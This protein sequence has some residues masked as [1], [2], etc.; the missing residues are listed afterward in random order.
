MSLRVPYGNIPLLFCLL[1]TGMDPARAGQRAPADSV[2]VAYYSD[3]RAHVNDRDAPARCDTL[4]RRAGEAGDLRLQ[5]VALCLRLDHYYFRN[6][7]ERI[8]EHVRRVKEFCAAHPDREELRYFYYFAWGSRLITFHIKQNQSNVAVYETRRMLTEAQEEGYARGVAMCYGLLG[9]LYMTQGDSRS[10]YDNFRMQ[11][12]EITRHGIDEINLPTQYAS[13]AQCALDLNM[14]DSALLALRKADSLRLRSA[15]QRFTVDKSYTLYHLHTGDLRAARQRLDSIEH[16]FRTEPRLATY[17]SG[18]YYIE[19]AYYR[20][21][22]EY[23]KAL[24]VVRRSQRDTVLRKT[25]YAFYVLSR[26]MGDIFYL[27]GDMPRAAASYREYIQAADSVRS[28]EVRIA[29]EDFSG[30]LELGRLQ[31]ETRQM[32]LDLQRRR[33]H[34]TYLVILLLGCLLVAGGALFARIVRLNRRLKV[35]EATVSRQNEHLLSAG[36]EL[37]AAKERAEQVSALKTSFIQNMSHEVRT[38]LNS[39]VGFSQVLASQFRNDTDASEYASIIE[40]SS[41]NLMRLIDDVLDISF[42]DQTDNLPANDCREM[43]SCCRE[44]TDGILREVADGVTV[45]CELSSENPVVR[46]DIRRV[47]QVLNHLLQNAAK[48]TERGTISLSYCCL[49][50]EGVLRFAVT[51]TGPGIPAAMREQ[52][53]ERFVKL[54]AFSQGSG[55]GLPV[56]RVIADKLGGRLY[57]DPTYDA[58]CRMIF[59]IPFLPA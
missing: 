59:E 26:D 32:Q 57:V 45:Q 42:L 2:L 23:G 31:D 9:N 16:A 19:A 46:T 21:A 10:A 36:R 14:P 43:N 6:D 53:F 25:D 47:A 33:L 28:R 17:R 1:L 12:D 22:G 8:I 35:S 3:I 55:L 24:D 18:L 5:A 51:D 54:D 50:E 48:F 13:M 11:T 56:C 58:G 7:R 27:Q 49:P 34:G 40:T 52:I 37:R 30:L 20:A 41:Q 44:C 38:P 39:I 29:T 15:Y 4:F